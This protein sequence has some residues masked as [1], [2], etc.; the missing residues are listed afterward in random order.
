MLQNE[1]T[2]NSMLKKIKIFE[3]ILFMGDT[4]CYAS[5]KIPLLF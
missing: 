5:K 1:F 4:P 2:M 3:F